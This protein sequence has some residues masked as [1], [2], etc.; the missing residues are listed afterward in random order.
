MSNANTLVNNLDVNTWK[1]LAI[2]R[3]L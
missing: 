1:H 2:N 3:I